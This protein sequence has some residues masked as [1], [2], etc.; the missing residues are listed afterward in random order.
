MKLHYMTIASLAFAIACSNPAKEGES[1][2]T[3]SEETTEAPVVAAE[4]KPA[5]CVWDEISV[6]ATPS[7]KGKWLTSLSLGESLTF[8]GIESVDSTDEDRVYSKVKLNDGTEGWSVS[9]LIIVEG[10]IGVFLEETFLYNRPDLLTK[11]EK[12]FEK[13]D[14]VA[15]NTEQDD[16]QEIIG[17]RGDARWIS[18]GW[19][20]RGKLSFEAVDIAAAKFLKDALSEDSD[21]EQIEALNTILENPD[22]KE[23]SILE[24]VQ[25]A[26]SEL[27]AP[28]TEIPADSLVE[29]EPEAAAS[30]E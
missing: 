21:E 18:K 16:W 17:R 27:T 19:I 9:D 22:L 8:M 7:A 25:T 30:V 2:A 3:N 28:E 5:V 26:L 11:S 10:Q 4:E 6:R 12:K 29:G 15:V 14:I 24:D 1:S 23:S 20:K 13:L